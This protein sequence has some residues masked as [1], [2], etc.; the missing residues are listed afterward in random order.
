MKRN[1]KNPR[2]RNFSRVRNG[3]GMSRDYRSVCKYI[4]LPWVHI[5]PLG[6]GFDDQSQQ[7]AFGP[8]PC[9]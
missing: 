9:R 2:R 4:A 7:S 3:A 5:G 6:G 1:E 8:I